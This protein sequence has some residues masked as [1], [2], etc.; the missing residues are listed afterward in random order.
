MITANRKVGND[1]VKTWNDNPYAPIHKL[2]RNKRLTA[3]TAHAQRR[4]ARRNVPP[5]AVDYVLAHGRTIQRTGVTFFFL[6][7]RDVPP[8]DRHTSW[9]SRLEGTTVLVASDG[10]V[11]TVYRN[12]RGLRAILRK[13]K[14][15]IPRSTSKTNLAREKDETN[16]HWPLSATSSE[17][18]TL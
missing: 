2:R 6:G 11:I 7:R 4:L 12:H 1:I 15:H 14:H 8:A 13:L 10:M 9:A 17:D 16:C 18:H 3:L 5:N